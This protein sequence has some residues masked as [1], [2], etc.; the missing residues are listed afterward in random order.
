MQSDYNA[1]DG[2]HLNNAGHALL[3]GRVRDA[4]I[5]ESL[6]QTSYA[7]E[8]RRPSDLQMTIYPHPTRDI[9]NFNIKNS[10]PGLLTIVITDLMGRQMRHVEQFV[11]GGESRQSISLRGLPL[12]MYHV[13]ISSG[14]RMSNGRLMLVR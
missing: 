4:R 13:I 8:L 12:G 14:E 2:V 5:P 7:A 6:M 11:P 10:Q 3:F 9:A 1:G